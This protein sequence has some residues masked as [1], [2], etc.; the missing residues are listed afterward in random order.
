MIVKKTNTGHRWTDTELKK[1]I[2][3]WLEG[4]ELEDIAKEFNTTRFAINGAILRMRRD[5]IPIP[6]RNQGH[7]AGRRNQL[8]TPQE[9]EYLVRRRNDK[10]TAEQIAVEL[11]RSFLA[12][13]SMIRVLRG[14]GVPVKM[15]GNGARRLWNPQDL[16]IAIAGRGLVQQEDHEN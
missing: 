9:T 4:R 7:K 11:D 1:L 12:V 10:A 16:K 8:W 14:E 6:R 5:G 2:G 13:Q 15:L 3:L